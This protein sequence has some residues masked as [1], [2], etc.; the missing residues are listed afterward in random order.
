MLASTTA[1][2]SLLPLKS[3][4]GKVMSTTS[5]LTIVNFLQIG[6]GVQ[7]FLGIQEVERLAFGG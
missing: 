6:F 5:P 7:V 3:V 1:S 2:R 4:N